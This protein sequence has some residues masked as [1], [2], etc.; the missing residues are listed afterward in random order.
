[1]ADNMYTYM[2][3]PDPSNPADVY[4][5][6]R[7]IDL[8]LMGMPDDNVVSSTVNLDI[9]NAEFTALGDYKYAI[10]EVASSDEDNF[11]IDT[12]HE[13]YMYVSVRNE[14]D[15]NGRPTGEYIATLSSQLRDH[16]TG[17]KVDAIFQ[18]RA[19]RSYITVKNEV[20]GNL[21]NVG[22]YFK[23]RVDIFGAKNGDEFTIEGQDDVVVYDGETI[24]T[25]PRIAIGHDNIIYLKH[26]Q[27]VTIGRS[28]ELNELPLGIRYVL[29]EIESNGYVQYVDEEEG[30]TSVEKTVVRNLTGKENVVEFLNHK[31]GNILTGIMLEIWPYILALSLMGVLVV[32]RLVRKKKQKS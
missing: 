24:I 18:N 13:Y 26:G 4:E 17:D 5:I 2:I 12:T 31:E 30:D 27:E 32:A 7:E 22:D 14:L 20:S 9:S 21:A 28:G 8:N 1:M 3:T 10:R 19:E 29:T 15:S 25:N 16:D 23:Y 11:P 6:P